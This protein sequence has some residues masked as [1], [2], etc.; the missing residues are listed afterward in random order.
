MG[1]IND[2]YA[3]T[4]I[5]AD[6]VVHLHDPLYYFLNINDYNNIQDH[7]VPN[8]FAKLIR[9]VGSYDY[10]LEGKGD[11]LSKDMVFRSQRI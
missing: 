9:N 10:L 2:T 11:F 1:F 7:L 3:G 8:A 6:C 4:R 5:V